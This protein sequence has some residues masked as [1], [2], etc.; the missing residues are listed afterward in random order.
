MICDLINNLAIQ[1]RV[2]MF[3]ENAR[4]CARVTYNLRDLS[5]HNARKSA[6]RKM[7]A[8]L[9]KVF[10]VTIIPLSYIIV[11]SSFILHYSEIEPFFSTYDLFVGSVNHGLLEP[12][13]YTFSSSSETIGW[14]L[15]CIKHC[16]KT[17]LNHPEQI[18]LSF[19][20]KV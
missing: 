15:R 19:V 7:F 12:S 5:K 13:L 17:S 9:V 16:N 1:F 20:R 18:H 3:Q 11:K 2:R 6:R 10:N 4:F 14:H 8:N